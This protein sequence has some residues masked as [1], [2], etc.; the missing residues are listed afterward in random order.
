MVRLSF[1]NVE[2]LKRMHYEAVK[3]YVSETMHAKKRKGFYYKVIELAGFE[4]YERD[5]DEEGDT[6][7]WLKHFCWQIVKLLSLGWSI[8]L[9]S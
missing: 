7:D 9:T 8:M 6:Y 4:A 1:P 2:E 3:S 5:Y